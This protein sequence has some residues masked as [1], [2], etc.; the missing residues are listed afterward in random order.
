MKI[1]CHISWNM[2]FWGIYVLFWTIRNFR[3]GIYYY[4][5]STSGEMEK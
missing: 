3:R 4:L 5:Y 1:Y 2:F